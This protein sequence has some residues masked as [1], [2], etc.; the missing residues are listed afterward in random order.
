MSSKILCLKD[1]NGNILYEDDIIYNGSFY[2]RIYYDK[3]H[4]EFQSIGINGYI[5]N[6]TPIDL[7]D[8][9]RIGTFSEHSHLLDCD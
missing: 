9:E 3:E 6:I 1:K 8:F 5:R 7:K 2:C 4:I